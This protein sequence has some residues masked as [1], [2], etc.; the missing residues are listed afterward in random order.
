MAL[1]AGYGYINKGLDSIRTLSCGQVEAGTTVGLQ[2]DIT[3][4]LDLDASLGGPDRTYSFHL[5]GRTAVR[6]RLQGAPAGM[7]M[8]VAFEGLSTNLLYVGNDLDTVLN[9]GTYFFNVDAPAGVS[10]AYGLSFDCRCVGIA[11]C[12]QNDYIARFTLNGVAGPLRNACEPGAFADDTATQYHAYFGQTVPM[13]VQHAS[14]RPDYDVVF[15]DLNDDGDFDDAGEKVYTAPTRIA[16]RNT[17]LPLPLLLP[18]HANAAGL[19]RMR[20]RAGTTLPQAACDSLRYGDTKEFRIRLQNP[21]L[22]LSGPICAGDT[23]RF[24]FTAPAGV[25]IPDTATLDLYR[26]DT[27]QRFAQA[28]YGRPYVLLPR[29]HGRPGL[30]RLRKGPRLCY[31]HH[32]FDKHCASRLRPTAHHP[33][34][35]R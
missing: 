26:D 20:V 15:I 9:R 35:G 13:I 10:G 29:R 17:T 1:A 3:D 34:P 25:V 16:T 6:L 27:R 21:G 11:D 22:T 28:R 30:R 5:A 31:R 4:Y 18:G 32:G 12:G 2:N 7:R 19:H 33:P 8:V 24:S 23:S 14:G